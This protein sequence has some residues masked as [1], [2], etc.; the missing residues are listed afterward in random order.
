MKI[1]T[2]KSGKKIA[3]SKTLRPR[4]GDTV[5][6]LEEEWAYIK[7]MGFSDAHKDFLWEQK[8]QNFRHAIIP[9]KG[10]TKPDIAVKYC[11]D[12]LEKMRSRRKP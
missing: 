9:E 6:F 7:A 4:D 3:F 1:Y 11:V 2:L 8:Y 12:I 5:F 10:L